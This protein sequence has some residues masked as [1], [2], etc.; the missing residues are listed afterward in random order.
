MQRL[1]VSLLIAS[2]TSGCASYVQTNCATGSYAHCDSGREI[3]ITSNTGEGYAIRDNLLFVSKN[4]KFSD[5]PAS[6]EEVLEFAL[7]NPDFVAMYDPNSDVATLH[8]RVFDYQ[9]NQGQVLLGM[10]L[11]VVGTAAVVAI[12]RSHENCFDR[13]ISMYRGYQVQTKKNIFDS[14]DKGV[15][16]KRW[17]QDID[18][19]HH[20][21]MN[22]LNNAFGCLR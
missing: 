10:A 3:A 17:Q 8:R 12:A 15:G 6:K 7:R 18:L 1:L 2:L 13:H 16:S 14:D 21:A 20:N 22:E 5:L 19:S 9:Q 11:L 4:G